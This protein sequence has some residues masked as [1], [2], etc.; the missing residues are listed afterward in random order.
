MAATDVHT[1]Y[2]QGAAMS[3]ALGWLHR[4]AFGVSASAA[5]FAVLLS[6]FAVA[7]VHADGGGVAACVAVLVMV[8]PVAFARRAPVAVAAVLAAGTAANEL[9]FGPLVRCGPG[10]PASFY[11]AYVLGNI[12][13]GWVRWLGLGLVLVG[14]ELQCV[15]DPQLGGAQIALMAP[16]AMV[17]FGAGSVARSRS[18]LATQL[19][20][21]NAELIE[22]RERTARVA[23]AGD[24]ER[25][26]GELIVGLQLQ[27]GEVARA[28]QSAR[29]RTAAPREG[30]AAIER[31]ARA[32]LER[33]R[34]IVG[35]IHCP[36][37]GPEPGMRALGDLL[38]S[39]TSCDA[40][41][42]VEGAAR[43]LPPSIELSGYRIVER[44]LAALADD[45]G[46]RA[47]VRVRFAADALELAV[48]GPIAHDLD[49]V[50]SFTGIADR[51]ALHGG[52][53][54]LTR[55]QGRLDARVRLPLVTSFA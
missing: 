43:P 27:I 14:V 50:L 21:R 23:V 55:P 7:L 34:D 13:T 18:A 54:Q 32:A 52:S 29:D 49:P 3:S 1:G 4:S 41:L 17:F 36:P 19:R 47:D 20:R 30:L 8:T 10:L 51:V 16:V 42:R 5:I 26:R 6:G 25:I 33:M 40:R 39:A 11:T 53:V 22:Q 37:T 24:R 38:N 46:A 9:F 35:T 48:T 2:R 31:T 44:L 15:Y 45:P 28:A 12:R